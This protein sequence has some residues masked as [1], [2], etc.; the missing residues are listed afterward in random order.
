MENLKTFIQR[1]L[2]KPSKMKTLS[3]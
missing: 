1:M 2:K 3:C